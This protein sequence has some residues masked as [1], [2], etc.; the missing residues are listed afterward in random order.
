MIP[1]PSLSVTPANVPNVAPPSKK[2]LLLITGPQMVNST[3][4]PVVNPSTGNS[5]LQ[6]LMKQYSM[7]LEIPSTA[8]EQIIRFSARF[9]GLF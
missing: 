2:A 1:A 8:K 3:A 4:K 5:F 7:V 6:L 9:S